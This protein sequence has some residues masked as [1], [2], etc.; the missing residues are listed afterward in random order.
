MS[1]LSVCVLCVSGAFGGQE[2]TLNPPEE[3]LRMVVSHHVGTE[4]SAGAV[5]AL[6]C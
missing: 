3:K 1:V 4:S 2:R 6:N 5:S